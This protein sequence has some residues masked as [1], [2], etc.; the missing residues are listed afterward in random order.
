MHHNKSFSATTSTS[1]KEF[2]WRKRKCNNIKWCS[3]GPHGYSTKQ[4]KP[5]TAWLKYPPTNF[6]GVVLFLLPTLLCSLSIT[7]GRSKG[8]MVLGSAMGLGSL[9]ASPWTVERWRGIRKG[10]NISWCWNSWI[11]RHWKVALLKWT[12]HF[13]WDLKTYLKHSLKCS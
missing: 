9:G 7:G 10:K 11:P 13:S 2:K 8:A 6:W 5:L 3:A 12:D 1:D 4:R